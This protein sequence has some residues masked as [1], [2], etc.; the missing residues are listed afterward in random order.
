MTRI[1]WLREALNTM[2]TPRSGRPFLSLI[3]MCGAVGSTAP[4]TACVL[5]MTVEDML[6]AMEGH[7]SISVRQA[8]RL[9][10]YLEILWW[11]HGYR[12]K[13]AESRKPAM[14]EAV[15]A[16]CLTIWPELPERLTDDWEQA[17]WQHVETEQ[18]FDF[19]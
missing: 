15:A 2:S 6:E 14:I 17:Y 5:E 13:R 9:R 18:A 16:R 7:R 8:D 3:K 4:E 10:M 11:W 1:S 12:S 19:V